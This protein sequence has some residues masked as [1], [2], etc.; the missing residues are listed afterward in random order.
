MAEDDNVTMGNDQSLSHFASPTVQVVV[1]GADGRPAQTFYL[2][3]ALITSRSRFFA[4]ALRDAKN[5]GET[6]DG[7][8]AKSSTSSAQW[9]EGEEGVVKLPFDEPEVFAA[10]AQLIYHGT[11]PDYDGPHELVGDSCEGEERACDKEIIAASDKMYSI[12]G[13]LY[14]LCEKIQDAVAK[15]ILLVAFVDA[16]KVL[17]GNGSNYYPDDPT[18]TAIYSGTSPSDPLRKYLV[19]NYV[20]FGW[21][22]WIPK[23]YSDLP[24]EF[25]FD[26]L[27]AMY[28]EREAPR[29]TSILQD[30][31]YYLDQVNDYQRE[32]DRDRE[33]EMEDG[34]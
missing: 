30:R 19:E 4:K 16:A 1:G 29:D 12:L 32:K 27:R 20:Y 34:R 15:P 28:R 21:S 33:M 5:T 3:A 2:H 13:R 26:V 14:V 6:N 10:Y 22:S 8:P 7:Q 18:V 25:L 23:A 31:Q 11:V 17:R 24:H 9:R